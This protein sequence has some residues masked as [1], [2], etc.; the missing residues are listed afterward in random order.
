MSLHF[1]KESATI[2]L[3]ANQLLCSGNK[4]QCETV[5]NPSASIRVTK[6]AHYL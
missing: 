2:V 4:K 5:P 3:W 6:G 1:L